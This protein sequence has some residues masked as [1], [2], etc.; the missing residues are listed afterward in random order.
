MHSF[1]F[2]EHLMTTTLNPLSVK[3]LIFYLLRFS[4]FVVAVVLCLERIL[5]FSH[6]T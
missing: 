1:E 4:P 3:F 2:S 6:F 5:L